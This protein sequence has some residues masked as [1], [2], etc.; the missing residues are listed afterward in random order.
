MKIKHFFLVLAVGYLVAGGYADAPAEFALEKDKNGVKV[1]TRKIEGS[2][3]KE[4]KGVTA[5]KTSLASLVALLDDTDALPQWLH[6]CGAAK[7]VQ[8]IN[9]AERITYTTVK[10]PWPVS[11]RDTVSYSKI[12]Q[13]PK[14]K[15]VTV[16]LKGLADRYPL[17]SG[18]VRVPSMKGFWQF[19][20][21]KSGYVTII[22][23]LHSEPGGSIP[24]AL[25]NSTATDMPYH[26]LLN[27]HKIVKEEKY[28]GAK[29]SQ[30]KELN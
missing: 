11:D 3:L 12:V 21:N 19:I 25:A 18:K 9:V 26:T 6:N 16:Y 28:Q 30:I 14:S 27:M 15:V 23:Q 5:I 22:Y 1:Y 24:D 10:A 2:A 29:L 8:N 13:D 4:F 20:P 17:Q 7:L